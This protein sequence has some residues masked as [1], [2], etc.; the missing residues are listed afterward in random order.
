MKNEK[1]WKFRAKTTEN[2]GEL[3][4]YGEIS[5]STWWGDEITPKQFKTDLDA[6]GDIK[7]LNIYINSPGGDV[8]AGQA[9]YTMLRRH[10]AYK[11]VYVDGLAGS[12]ASVV[13]MAGDKIIMAKGS[14]MF[15]HNGAI[16]LMGFYN[17]AK[18]R[19]YADEIE[20]ITD[21]VVVPSYGRTGKTAEEI[22]I[23][24]DADTWMTDSEAV[25]QK[26]AD[27]IE[28]G[29]QYAASISDSILTINGQSVNLLSCKTVPSIKN[30]NGAATQP[31]SDKQKQWFGILK[32]KY[33]L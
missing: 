8:F 19:K 25:E 31:V 28:E 7:N 21:N 17:A 20:K 23:M 10:T 4:L 11:T 22:K 6:L 16:G 26:F 30:E 3:D 27:E 32:Q 24:L 5:D 33:K 9:I 13:A 18:L 29:K 15:I 12:I 1:F 14:M 2:T